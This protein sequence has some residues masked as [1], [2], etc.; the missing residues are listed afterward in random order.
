MNLKLVQKLF[1]SYSG[2][3]KPISANLGLSG[4]RDVL[5]A[6]AAAVTSPEPPLSLTADRLL[7]K[8]IPQSGS[9]PFVSERLSFPGQ[10][11]TTSSSWLEPCRLDPPLP[12]KEG[13]AADPIWVQS[14]PECGDVSALLASITPVTY[15]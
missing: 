9:N 2:D 4:M 1:T 10:A 8:A 3:G 11:D 12:L 15:R 7:R 13:A 5:A 6:A 14:P